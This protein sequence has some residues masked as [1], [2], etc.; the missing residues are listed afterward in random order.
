MNSRKIR[1]DEKKLIE[2][3]LAELDD[4]N[5]SFLDTGE[6]QEIDSE[7]SIKFVR[8]HD[9]LS[10]KYLPVEAEFMDSDGVHVHAMV[11]VIDNMVDELEIY[12]SDGSPILH[13]PQPEDWTILNLA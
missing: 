5:I 1:S 3:I 13:K 8:D 11:F 6:V 10:Q 2:I 9:S 7:G 4:K 12:K